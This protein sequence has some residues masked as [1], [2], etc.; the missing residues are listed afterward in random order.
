MK[1]R[2][3]FVFCL[4]AFAF[5]LLPAGCRKNEAVPAGAT[6]LP[7]VR[8]KI[9]EVKTVPFAAAVSVTG[10]L[11]SR[12]RVDV[13]AETIGRV[14]R[15]PKEEGDR[16]TAG[17]AMVWVNDADYRLAVQ[18]AA[19]AVGVADAA[20]ERSKVLERHSVS[21]RE[22]AKNLVKSG[23]ITQKDLD[24]AELAA[25]DAKAQ[26]ALVEAQLAQARAALEVA[27]K[28]L[29]DTVIR[30]P[31]TGEIQHKFVNPGAYVEA[32]TAVFTLVDNQ[33]LELESPVPS[34]E[35]SPI[36]PSQPVTFAVASYPG[37]TF[38]GNVVEINPALDTDTRS[39]K[40]R[41]RVENRRGRLKAGMFAQGEIRTGAERPTVLVPSSAVS[42]DDRSSK[43]AFVFVVENGKAVRKPV[44][45]GR[46]RNGSLEVVE[47]LQP[48]DR[49]IA[50]Q[51]IEIADGVR[52]EAGG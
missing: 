52:V 10:T 27:R 18:Q 35:L 28:R 14:V 29:Q 43:D 51:S 6:E 42:R 36:R 34:S 26:V 24:A 22:R 40:V 13:K 4:L 19:S 49:L 5:C 25:R 46:E 23:G 8:A 16:V 15:F 41:I 33:R 3:L 30:A 17:E 38:E 21:E 47:G 2:Q 39:A 7:A 1:R 20:L 9:V 37:E 31:V 11:V 45:I 12:S 48:G 32:P 50:E 44:R